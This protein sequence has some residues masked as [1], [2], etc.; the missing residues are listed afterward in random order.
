M[1]VCSTLYTVH[2]ERRGADRDVGDRKSGENVCLFILSSDYSQE[3]KTEKKACTSIHHTSYTMERSP[4][5]FG[6]YLYTLEWGHK[7]AFL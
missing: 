5:L 4:V 6:H 1:K 7:H 3:Y 2:L